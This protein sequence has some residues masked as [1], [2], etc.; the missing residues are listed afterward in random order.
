MRTK[1]THIHERE[2]QTERVATHNVKSIMQHNLV[3][4]ITYGDRF[5]M[6]LIYDM[7]TVSVS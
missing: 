3:N 2:P 4:E 1:N 7:L 5:W 6:S